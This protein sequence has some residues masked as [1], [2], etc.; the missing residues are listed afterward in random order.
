V[1]LA[2]KG[3]ETSIL[4]GSAESLWDETGVARELLSELGYGVA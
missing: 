1:L 4:L 2:G 3:H